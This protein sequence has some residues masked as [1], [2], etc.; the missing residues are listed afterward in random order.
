MSRAAGI[1]VSMKENEI[2]IVAGPRTNY[3]DVLVSALNEERIPARIVPIEN[4]DPAN[5][6]KWAWS[7]QT[8]GIMRSRFRDCGSGSGETKP[9]GVSP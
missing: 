6:P 8:F 3:M 4:V 7:V 5:R 2:P 1:I 9:P